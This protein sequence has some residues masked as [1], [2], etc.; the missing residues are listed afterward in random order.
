M[1]LIKLSGLRASATTLM[2]VLSCSANASLIINEIMQNPSAVSDSNG[3]W[4]E[5][6][7]SGLTDIDI[8]GWLIADIDID[9]HTINNGGPLIISAGAFLVL[10]SNVDSTTNG[11]V[12]IDYSY[13]PSFFLANGADELVLLDDSLVEVD[14]VEWDNG[15]TFPDPIGASMALTSPGVD[16]N[17]GA[18]WTVSTAAF[19]N[20]DLG[21]PGS[22]N[23]DIG[24]DC[25]AS[26]PIPATLALCVLGLA[27]LGWSRRKQA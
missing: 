16:N 22:C 24:Q 27:G 15:L 17:L 1:K 7:N 8:N 21:T 25:S 5:L 4:F 13:G 2:L 20:G 6:F 23:I 12:D 11:G 14:R 9:S 26:V 19:G 3:E 10:G 18:S